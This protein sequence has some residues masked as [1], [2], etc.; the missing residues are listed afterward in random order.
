MLSKTTTDLQHI[1]QSVSLKDVN[2]QKFWVFDIGSHESINAT[3][4]VN[5]GFKQRG[6]EDSQILNND[7]FCRLPVT[8]A[9]G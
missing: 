6:R 9:Q 2:D 1:E 8:S 4:W 7:T 5:I 3:I